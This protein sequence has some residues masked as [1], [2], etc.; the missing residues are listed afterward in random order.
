MATTL[1]RAKYIVTNPA[2]REDG[3]IADGGILV[4]DS[5]IAEV[6]DFDRLKANCP[7]SVIVGSD[8]HMAIPGF[9]DA[10]DHGQGA[11]TFGLGIRD[12]LLETWSQ[13]W[14]GYVQRAARHVYW[15]SLVAA[16]RQI[17]SGVTTCMRQ[18]VPAMPLEAYRTETEA[19]L[20]AYA[21]S[22]LRF[23][24]ALGTN[25]QV[26]LVYGD[27]ESFINSLPPDVQLTARKLVAPTSRI[28]LD[29]CLGYLTDLHH[30]YAS[31][32]RI[33]IFM[34]V[35]GPQ[36]DSDGLLVRFRDKASE[37]GTGMHG[38]LLETLYQKLYAL[39]E[40]GHSAAEHYNRLGMLGRNYSCAH[41]VWLSEKDID[42]FAEAGASVV[43]CPSSNLRL[44]SGIAPV[45][46]MLAKGVNV[47]LS[48]DS[49][50]VNDDDDTFQ[51]MRLAMML[52]RRPGLGLEPPDEWDVL[53]MATTN[54][55]QAVMMQDRIGTIEQGKEADITLVR[56]DRIMDRYL[57]PTINPVT[58]LVYLGKPQ[59]VDLVMVSGEVIM[60][61]GSCTRFDEAAAL[62][63]LKAMMGARAKGA[64]DE[65]NAMRAQVMPYVRQYYAGWSMPALDPY[66][67]LNSKQ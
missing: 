59:D 31:T 39:R 4:R 40:F 58:A 7:D 54:G 43:H 36:W 64:E 65:V 10:H 5:I 50:G 26:G 24:C 17:R 66:Y 25:D 2:L 47:A 12:A 1:I 18:D 23:V 45:P 19:L 15:D 56:L 60:Q 51:E 44:F 37:L 35:I 22:G 3:L 62:A 29:E 8:R 61:G 20:D 42:L 6:G 48:V 34:G 32:L 14:P 33:R 67:I 21:T 49:E 63:G 11:T 27:N 9:V 53:K 28:S 41:G 57:E 13:Y 46:M 52:H 55:A 30:R 16:A 38:P